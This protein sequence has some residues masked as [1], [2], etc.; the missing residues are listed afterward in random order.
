[1]WTTLHAFE[2]NNLDGMTLMLA[3]KY[4]QPCFDHGRENVDQRITW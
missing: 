1:M 4:G 2:H 3:P